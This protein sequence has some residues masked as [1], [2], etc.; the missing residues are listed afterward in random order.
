MSASAMPASQTCHAAGTPA[1]QH[2]KGLQDTQIAKMMQ[3]NAA[4]HVSYL[5][6]FLLVTL[7]GVVEGALKTVGCCVLEAFLQVNNRGANTAACQQR[8]P[9]QVMLY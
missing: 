8:S 2:Y 5:T 4:Q 7:A 6:D 9:F 1:A 3:Q